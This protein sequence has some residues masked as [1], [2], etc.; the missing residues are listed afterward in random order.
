[1][2]YFADQTMTRLNAKTLDQ[3]R[4]VISSLAEEGL[5]AQ[6]RLAAREVAALLARD[7]DMDKGEYNQ[8]EEFKAAAVRT[9]S[10]GYTFLFEGPDEEGIRRIWAHPDEE[11]VYSDLAVLKEGQGAG[12][13]GFWRAAVDAENQQ[14]TFGTY[15]WKGKNRGMEEKM[16]ACVAVPDSNYIIAA[17]GEAG[18]GPLADVAQEVR[19]ETLEIG[20][21]A[22]LF[23]LSGCLAMLFFGFLFV[24]GMVNRLRVLLQCADRI[25]TG[26]IEHP[27]FVGSVFYDEITGL[28]EVFKRMQTSLS[29]AMVRLS[30]KD[31]E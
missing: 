17:V 4:L 10:G 15:Q 14:A 12:F 29:L 16:I 13:Q 18:T 28:A 26:D 3:A 1:M 6:A 22:I 25:S 8:D 11:I 31:K 2:F 20:R 9:F 19:T 5:S 30:G 21:D 27:V 24:R 7:P 23:A